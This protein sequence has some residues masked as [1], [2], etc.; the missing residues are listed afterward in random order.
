MAILVASVSSDSS[1][2]SMGTPVGRVILFGTIPTTIADTVPT[3]SPPA[4]HTDTTEIPTIAPTTPLSPDY[5]PT[6]L[7]YSPTP[8]TE[9]DPFEDY[10]IPPLQAISPFLSST[11]DTTDSDTPDTPPSP[12]HAYC[13]WSTVPLPSYGPEHMMNARKRVGPLPVQQ[14]AVGHPLDHSSSDYFFADDLAQDSSTDSSSEASS[15]FHSD[16]SSDSSSRHSLSDHS[17]PDLLSTFAR[18][19][20]KRRSDEPHLEQDIDPEIQS[21][22]NECIA[23]A[24]ALRD[25][26]NDARVVVKVVDREESETGTRGLVKMWRRYLYD[27]K[28]IVFNDHKSLQHILDQKELNIRQRSWLELLSDYD[29]EIG[30]HPGK[31]NVVANALS[32]KERSKPLR[33]WA[34]VMTIGLNLPKQILSAQSKAKK[35][36]NFV[37]EDL[38]GMINKLKPRAD[39]T[40][41]LNNQSWILCYGDLRA[42]ILHEPHKSK[43]SIHPGSDKMYRDL[44]KL[45]WW[46]NMKAEIST[47]VTLGTQLDMSTTYHP[48]IDGL[49]ERTIQTLEDML[50][51]CVLDFGK[52]QARCL[53]LEAEISKLKHKIEKDDHSEMIKH[54]S[55]IELD[56]LNLQLK[57]LAR[58]WNLEEIHVAWAH[59]KK[60]RTRLRLYT[61]NHEELFIQSL[62]TAS[63]P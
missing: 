5:T 1:E 30:Y 8:D 11:D 28:C 9:F 32:Q 59:L 40:L 60:K 18:P 23:Y 31:A 34:L 25:R 49:S 57:I 45:Y 54:F 36:K 42:L 46:P 41:C 2:E 7:D 55:N 19:S 14:I 58:G 20:R 52:G 22:I 33:V 47:Y 13:S 44:K 53:E 16:A 6:S 12:T 48:R 24:D 61:K 63:Q 15:D 50:R 38:H 17:S 37:V 56:H 39:G 43:Y 10:H 62:E 51:A 27:T 3:I 4:T 29:C 21:E 26:E 35:E